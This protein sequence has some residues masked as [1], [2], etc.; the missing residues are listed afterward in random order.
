MRVIYSHS[1]EYCLVPAHHGSILSHY[2]RILFKRKTIKLSFS[3]FDLSDYCVLGLFFPLLTSFTH[4][5]QK[6]GGSRTPVLWHFQLH[7]HYPAG[8]GEWFW[9]SR[10]HRM[11]AGGAQLLQMQCGFVKGFLCSA[12]CAR[13]LC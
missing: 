12:G 11:G 3:S 10:A 6:V 7:V 1:P 5:Y 13:A 9:L 2:C 8:N 4:S